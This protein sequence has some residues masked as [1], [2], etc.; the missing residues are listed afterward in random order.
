MLKIFPQIEWDI[1]VF[2]PINLFSQHGTLKLYTC[3]C[4]KSYYKDR[5]CAV[6]ENPSVHIESAGSKTSDNRWKMEVSFWISCLKIRPFYECGHAF[7][8]IWWLPCLCHLVKIKGYFF[9]PGRPVFII[10]INTSCSGVCYRIYARQKFLNNALEP[11]DALALFEIFAWRIS[12]NK[13]PHN[14]YLLLHESS[15]VEIFS[16]AIKFKAFAAYNA[17]GIR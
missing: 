16:L 7:K 3:M 5:K 14:R 4:V 9:Q 17:F 15:W 12:C 2:A 1:Y 10:V 11:D 13:R 8:T 6:N